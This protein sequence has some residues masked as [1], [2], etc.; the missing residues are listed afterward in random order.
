MKLNESQ[1]RH[2][3]TLKKEYTVQIGI[4]KFIIDR[5]IY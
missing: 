2:S 5:Y 1:K 4:G 3:N